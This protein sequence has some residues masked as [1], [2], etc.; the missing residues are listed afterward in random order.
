MPIHSFSQDARVPRARKCLRRQGAGGRVQRNLRLEATGMHVAS[1][2][3]IAKADA[4]VMGAAKGRGYC[5]GKATIMLHGYTALAGGR[6][7]KASHGGRRRARLLLGIRL[8]TKM[9]VAM[10]RREQGRREAGGMGRPAASSGIWPTVA[11]SGVLIA[12][13][14]GVA[15]TTLR[16]EP[17]RGDKDGLGDHW[18]EARIGSVLGAGAWGG[19]A[20]T[21]W[22]YLTV[23]LAQCALLERLADIFT[24]V[25]G[26]NQAPVEVSFD[27]DAALGYHLS[28]AFESSRLVS[29]CWGHVQGSQSPSSWSVG[30]SGLKQL[31]PGDLH[32]LRKRVSRGHGRSTEDRVGTTVTSSP[33]ATSSLGD[34]TLWQGRLIGR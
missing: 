4:V 18:L 23:R 7:E 34:N 9:I 16:S 31:R 25:Q 22:L 6:N 17:L 27:D 19:S 10:G 28:N 33:S 12:T 21:R 14:D 11:E 32:L 1:P 5:A 24:P 3:A 20:G 26:R 13:T 29:P 30:D 8:T 15:R 2:R